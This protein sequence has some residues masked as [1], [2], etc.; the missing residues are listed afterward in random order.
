MFICKNYKITRLVE[1][2]FEYFCYS[3]IKN[4]KANMLG[5]SKFP[6]PKPEFRIKL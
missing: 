6:F 1:P 2:E 5:D 3:A 4:R